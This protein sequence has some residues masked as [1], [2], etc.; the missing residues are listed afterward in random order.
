MTQQI[1]RVDRFSVPAAARDEFLGYVRNTHEILRGLPGF[2][3]DTVLEQ[4][5][6]L[7]RFNIV[8]MVIWESQE[9]VDGALVAVVAAHK[10]AGFD[11]RGTLSRLGIDA[12]VGRYLEAQL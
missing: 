1:Y 4:A 2:V 6:R 9:A 7:G 5:E 11:R 10:K 3:E 8:T 12:D